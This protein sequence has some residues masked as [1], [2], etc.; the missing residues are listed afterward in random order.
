[1]VRLDFCLGACPEELFDTLVP[2]APYHPYSVYY[3]YTCGNK[4]FVQ[5][6]NGESTLRVEDVSFGE[7]TKTVMAVRST[8]AAQTPSSLRMADKKGKVMVIS[9]SLRCDAMGSFIQAT[10]ICL[11]ADENRDEGHCA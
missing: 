2:E 10:C 9:D 7:P 8:A 3:R 5:A 4:Q 6:G 11:I 1:M